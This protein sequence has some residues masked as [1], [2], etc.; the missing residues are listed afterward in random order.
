MSSTLYLQLWYRDVGGT[1]D[2][3]WGFADV[4]MATVCR[5]SLRQVLL[6]GRVSVVTRGRAH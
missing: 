5:I 6:G 3:E 1:S 2:V 4:L